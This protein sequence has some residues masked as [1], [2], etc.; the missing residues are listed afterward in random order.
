M[1][2]FFA[3]LLQREQKVLPPW[4]QLVRVLRRLEARGEVRGG[5]FV[6]GFG[7]EQFAWPEA[8]KALRQAR[9]ADTELEVVVSAADPLNLAGIITP[10]ERI[11]STARNR[12]LYRGGVPVAVLAGGSFRWLVEADAAAEWSARSLLMRNDPRLM[13][14]VGSA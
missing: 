1:A 8:V 10:G 9:T 3:C 14:S 4:R 5:R 11:P 13:M 7:G 12:L 2:W 6:N